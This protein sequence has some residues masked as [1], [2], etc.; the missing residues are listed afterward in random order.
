MG[1][2]NIRPG[3][4]GVV[5]NMIEAENTAISS[6]QNDLRTLGKKVDRMEG[7]LETLIDI[8]TDTFYVVK[9]QYVEK[10][11]KIRLEGKFEE[12]SDLE[13]LKRSLEED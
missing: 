12:F 1:R 5:L 8:Y 9:D 2:F 7:M 10:L 6:I 4:V 3:K 11:Q 13:S